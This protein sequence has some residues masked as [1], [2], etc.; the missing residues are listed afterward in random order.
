[1]IQCRSGNVYPAQSPDCFKVPRNELRHSLRSFSVEV[2]FIAGGSC[3]VV[4]VGGTA[5]VRVC[6]PPWSCGG[7]WFRNTVDAARDALCYHLVGLRDDPVE[8]D[9]FS[10]PSSSDG[11]D[12]QRGGRV[13]LV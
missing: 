12:G 7:P 9:A 4:G 3:A 10:L 6:K 13:L 5:C 2:I 1:M 8:A 11:R